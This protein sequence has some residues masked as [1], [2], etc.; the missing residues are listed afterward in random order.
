[1]DAQAT[2]SDLG[3]AVD[4]IVAPYV[5]ARGN[6]GL[7]VGVICR[8]QT[9]A[10]GYGQTAAGGGGGIVEDT[11]FEI[12]SITKVFTALLLA[13]AVTR[14]VVAL[15]DP[16]RKY[17][18]DS[19]QVPKRGRT[20][21]TLLHL[22]THTSGL[23]RLP[24]NMGWKDVLDDNP[25]ARYTVDDLYDGLSRCRLK[26]EPGKNSEYSNLGGGLLGHILSLVEGSGFE[27]LVKRRICEP[28]AMYD[29]TVMLTSDQASR[30][31]TGHSGGKAV[32]NWDMPALAGAGALRSSVADLLRFLAANMTPPEGAPGSAI[33]LAQRIHSG[34]GPRHEVARRWLLAGAV[35]TVGLPAMWALKR[36]LPGVPQWLAIAASLGGALYVKSRV[37]RAWLGRLEPMGLGW[38]VL[39][40]SSCPHRVLWHNGGTGGYCSF[41]GFVREQGVGVVLLANSDNSVDEI[42]TKLLETLVARRS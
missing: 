12:G 34:D 11:L 5:G 2:S 6:V 9:M 15:D 30:L 24:T 8:E 23:P 13:D 3:R 38:H 27:A 39:S 42:G 41:L 21:M 18:P 14:G 36:A 16:V 4:E 28:L 29:T 19:V 22:A 31:A 1:M 20:E 37:E 35:V 7:A 25:Y 26:S 17:L 10:R 32:S 33:A 40:L